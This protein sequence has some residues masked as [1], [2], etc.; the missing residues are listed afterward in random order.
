MR[1]FIERALAK[2]PKMNAQQMES[3]V[4]VLAEENKRFE[5]VFDSLIEGVIVCDDSHIAILCNKTAERLI[6]LALS[7]LFEKKLWECVL[8]DEMSSFLYEALTSEDRIIDREFTFQPTSNIKTV[9]LS[10]TPLIEDN[11]I[12][13]TMITANDI[14]EKKRKEILLRRAESLASL[15]TLAAG[16]AHEIKNPLGSM[17][18]HVQLIKKALK[19]KDSKLC[20]EALERYTAVIDEE[21][22]RLNH[23]VVDFLFAVRPMNMDLA[24][25]N[26]NEFLAGIADFIRP[27]L[28][29]SNI[30]IELDLSDK[31]I[32]LPIDVRYMKQAILNLIKNSQAA[33]PNGGNITIGLA[34]SESTIDIT[35]SDNGSGISEENLPKIFEPYFTTKDNGTGLGLTLV[36]KIIKEHGGDVAVTTKENKGTTFTL[37]L[38]I[39]QKETKLIPYN[40]DNLSNNGNIISRKAKI[41]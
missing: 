32:H 14:T 21:I 23:I 29:E 17:S 38:P 27:E 11:S 9:T 28:Q 6:P 33:M 41:L 13:G 8:D 20:E 4:G 31:T 19:C 16:V 18:I 12:Q 24:E 40:Y 5:A 36:F 30:D 25:T 2:V 7:D 35:I 3:F 22:K 26:L 15:T 37:A 34:D 1:G 39:P 10:V